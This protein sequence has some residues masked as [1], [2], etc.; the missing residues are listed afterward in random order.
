MTDI[1]NILVPKAG[2]EPVKQAMITSDK[3]RYSII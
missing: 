2:F 3:Q 1:I